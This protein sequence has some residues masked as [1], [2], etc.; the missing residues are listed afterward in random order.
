MKMTMRWFGEQDTITLEQIAQIPIMRGIVGTFEGKGGDVVWTEADFRAMKANIESHGLSLDVIESIPVAEAI[1]KGTPER[2]A[3]ID[4][5]CES[6]RNMGKAGI[7]VLCYNFMPVFDWMRTNLHHEFPDGSTATAYDHQAML[8]YD[9]SRGL[10]ARVAWARGYS[11]DELNAIFNEYKALDEEGLF[12]NFAYFLRRVVP[13]A[14]EAGVFMALHPD[15]PP[16]PI[17][18]LPRIVR[19]AATIQRILDVVDS[20]HNGLTFCTGSLGALAA[21]D[22]PAMV[23]QFAGR[24]NFAHLRNV[25]LTGDKSFVEV[26]HTSAAGN[27]D[28]PTVIQALIDIG[29][30]GPVR[31][32]HGRMIWGETGRIGYGLY[33]RALAAMYLHGVW[34]G[35]KH[36]G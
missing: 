32:D 36:Q 8:D 30:T 18:G 19:D 31:P 34:Q 16:W 21:N 25:E 28:M 15:D 3:L 11:G 5:F 13:V 10:E 20:P 27:V 29:F 35:L 4:I 23:R 22:L 1:K 9:L 2:D 7:P 17:F 12:Q 24:I 6:V 14:Q 33:D 26:A